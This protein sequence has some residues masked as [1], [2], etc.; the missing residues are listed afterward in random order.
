MSMDRRR[1]VLVKALQ[2]SDETVRSA[3]AEALEKLEIRAKKGY[4]EGLIDK[5][6]KLEKLRAVYALSGLRGQDI[7]DV[8]VKAL[9]DP[10]EDVR[11]A[12]L[13]VLG[14]IGDRR[15]L[16]DIIE[17]LKDPSFIVERVA[18]E[19]LGSYR[20]PEVVVPLL[21]MLKSKDAGVIEN[22]LLVIS[23]VGDK[24][25]EEAM[26]YFAVKGNARM[27]AVAMKALGMMDVS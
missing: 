2:D 16:P 9:K 5:G 26:I 12:S 20:E 15:V 7:L 24:R 21:Q 17:R 6:E 27:K 4:F 14:K 11:A 13:R 23:R 25:A 1:Q 8:L 22:A 10:V 3:A 18:V 19:A